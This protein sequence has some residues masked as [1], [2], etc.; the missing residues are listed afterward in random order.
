M[1]NFPAPLTG[2]QLLNG[3][4]H[5]NPPEPQPA[6]Q[7]VSLHDYELLVTTR[8]SFVDFLLGNGRTAV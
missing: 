3:S 6:L 5:S 2:S 4:Q 8:A 1:D 7:A